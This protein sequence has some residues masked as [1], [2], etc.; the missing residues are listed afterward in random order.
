[1]R[2]LD[3]VG[4]GAR[5]GD[6]VCIAI[7]P[8]DLDVVPASAGEAPPGALVGVVDAAL[9]VGERVEYQVDVEGQGTILIYGD[10]H[11]RARAGARAWL[12]PRPEGH[13]IWPLGRST[14]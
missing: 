11:T 8:E 1:I 12:R 5:T 10:R 9:F 13:T 4:T 2:A 6:A 14:T 7:R 3:T